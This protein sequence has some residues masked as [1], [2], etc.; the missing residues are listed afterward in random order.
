MPFDVVAQAVAV[1]GLGLLVTW[2]I[3]F[4]WALLHDAK[5]EVAWMKRKY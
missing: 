5:A 4:P 1:S 3:V 2:G